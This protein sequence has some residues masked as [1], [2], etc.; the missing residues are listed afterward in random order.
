MRYLLLAITLL[1]WQSPQE[2]KV[3]SSYDRFK[4]TTTVSSV[5]EFTR[6]TNGQDVRF[7]KVRAVCSYLGERPS[8][9]VRKIVLG[10]Q[11]VSYRW[12]FLPA[13]T[14]SLIILVDKVKVF[15]GHAELIAH[16]VAGDAMA[17]TIAADIERPIMDQMVKGKLAEIQIGSVELQLLPTNQSTLRQI[18]ESTQRK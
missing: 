5:Y 11:V 3:T 15:D 12:Q 13:Q 4:D 7:V 2:Q 1:L 14:T 8:V 18:L 16:D 6:F 10:F 17:E 9:T